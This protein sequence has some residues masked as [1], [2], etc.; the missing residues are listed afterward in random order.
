[1]KEETTGANVVAASTFDEKAWKHDYEIQEKTA[2]GIAECLDT[3]FSMHNEL[4]TK[5]G[6]HGVDVKYHIS[7]QEGSLIFFAE[8]MIRK[9]LTKI[10]RTFLFDIWHS[11]AGVEDHGDYLRNE[12]RRFMESLKHI[13]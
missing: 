6:F 2:K 9:G 7:R 13:A 1:M 4:K 3:I 11:F 5:L 12:A 10:E 8:F